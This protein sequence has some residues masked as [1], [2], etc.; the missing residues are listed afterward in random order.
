[1]SESEKTPI[2]EIAFPIVIKPNGYDGNI[3]IDN[4]S[5]F[6]YFGGSDLSINL[7]AGQHFINTGD[8]RGGM[9]GDDS[10][11][12]YFTVSQTGTITNLL[13]TDA[14]EILAGN[15]TLQFKTTAVSINADVF[16]GFYILSS[17][18]SQPVNAAST[19]VKSIVLIKAL[20][21]NI[22]S[23]CKI[24][25]AAQ[26]MSSDFRFTVNANGTIVL[27]NKQC[28]EVN[29]NE[30]RLK[31]TIAV[32]DPTEYGSSLT[33]TLPGNIAVNSKTAVPVIRG[34]LSFV[35]WFESGVEKVNYFFPL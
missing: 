14:A 20:T 5:N 28:A 3:S 32:V 21:Y 16:K 18:L 10:A 33:V 22:D 12:I 8:G 31:T 7:K 9:T 2:D 34:L 23:G 6:F 19:P 17:K 4:N 15:K 30:I 35:K 1:M 27:W 13:N 11:Y 29:G 24:A 26:N 25:W